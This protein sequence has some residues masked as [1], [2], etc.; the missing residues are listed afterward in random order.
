M[1][2]VD[3]LFYKRYVV[4][5]CSSKG[6]EVPSRMVVAA[7]AVVVRY[8]RDFAAPTLAAVPFPAPSL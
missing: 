4:T 2:S 8:G 1:L 6:I 7:A 3:R 5:Q